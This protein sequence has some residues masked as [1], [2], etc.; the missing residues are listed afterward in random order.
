MTVSFDARVFVPPHVLMQEMPD[1]DSVF[2][3]LETEQ[4][5]G[6]N[7]V[8]TRMWSRLVES[9]SVSAAY[10]AL[11]EEYD[12]DPT[13]LRSDLEALLENLFAQGL[14]TSDSPR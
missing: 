13:T 2:I 5:Y 4:Y 14:L 6:L 12:V 7:A 8:G 1:G 11:R 3:N 9:D 10:E